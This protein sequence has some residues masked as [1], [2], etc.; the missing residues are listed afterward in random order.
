[1]IVLGE[2]RATKSEPLVEQLRTNGVRHVAASA[3]TGITNGV[4]ILSRLPIEPQPAPLGAS[5]FD[6]WS[7][8]ADVPRSNLSVIGVYAPL[9]N[10]WGSSPQI[11]RDFWEAVC[12][13][14]DARRDQRL[15]L[16]GDFNT[17]RILELMDQ[18]CFLGGGRLLYGCPRSGGPIC[19]EHTTRTNATIPTFAVLRRAA[20]SGES[21]TPL[22]HVRWHSR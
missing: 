8:A 5:P 3:V 16:V 19:G 1:M 7:V 9:P 2:Y 17:W 11:H 14:A 15:L 21:T 22:P 18:T 10:S 13:M 4:A 12:S 20:R 6:K